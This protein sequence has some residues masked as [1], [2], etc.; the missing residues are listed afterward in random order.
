M[1]GKAFKQPFHEFFLMKGGLVV[2][3]AV[4]Y[5]QLAFYFQNRARSILIESIYHLDD[6]FAD[7]IL[8]NG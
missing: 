3:D 5:S 7:L 4:L 8:E 6:V 1:T 2:S